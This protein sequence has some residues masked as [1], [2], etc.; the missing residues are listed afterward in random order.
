M[1]FCGNPAASYRA[2]Q[3]EIDAAM[4]R[5]F[6]SERYI[7]GPEVSAFEEEFAAYLGAKQAVG[8]GSG[9]EALYLALRACEIGPGDEVITV[10]HTAVATISAIVHAG[11]TP[12][13]VD[14]DPRLYTL[15]PS[16]LPAV[17]TEKTKAIIPVHLY[18]QA[19]EM[20]P[21]IEFAREHNLKV[22]EDCAQATGGALNQHK[23]GTWGDIGCFS[24]Y[25]TKN[26]GAVG[27]GGMAVTESHA[28]AERIR[29][30]R[31]YGWND[32]AISCEPG[33]NSRLDE[34]QAAILRVKLPHLD[35]D[36]LKRGE[37]ADRYIQALGSGDIQL[38]ACR[39][40]REHV[41][42]LFVVRSPFRN[43]LMNHLRSKGVYALVHYPT[44]AHLHPAYAPFAPPEGTLEITEQVAG[45]ILSLPVY[46]ELTWEDQRAV[47]DAVN[48]FNITK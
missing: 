24:F 42:H 4:R 21:I 10:S 14:I 43:E 5:V 44:P 12:V 34:L 22:I 6:E 9:T 16:A 29:Q 23:L 41:F 39:P 27:D 11:A 18:G 47:I 46:P 7:L 36:N 40:E 26:L 45:E 28:L 2:Y 31:Q 32:A 48:Q 30:L 37:V 20:K 13:F 17:L 35:M 8:V 3:R 33:I 19:A 38:P 15:D 1:I 25:P